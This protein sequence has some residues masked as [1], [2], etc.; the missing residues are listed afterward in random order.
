MGSKNQLVSA[1]MPLLLFIVN[2]SKNKRRCFLQDCSGWQIQIWKLSKQLALL[3][4]IFKHLFSSQFTNVVLLQVVFQLN[5]RL[6]FLIT[7]LIKLEIIYSVY[8]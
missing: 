8:N 6:G 7:C 4:N 2:F 5:I 3:K 1:F